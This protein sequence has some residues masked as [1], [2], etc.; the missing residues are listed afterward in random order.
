[1]RKGSNGVAAALAG[2]TLLATGTG[3]FAPGGVGWAA[4]PRTAVLASSANAVFGA[5]SKATLGAKTAQVSIQI[6]GTEQASGVGPCEWKIEYCS[7]TL[8]ITIPGSGGAATT[9]ETA[10]EVEAGGDVYYKLPVGLGGSAT[11]P[12][13]ETSLTGTAGSESTEDEDPSQ[14][15][16][17]LKEYATSVIRVGSADVGAVATTEYSANFNPADLKGATAEQKALGTI[18]LK[19]WLDGRHRIVQLTETLPVSSSA[20]V[21]TSTVPPPTTLT[22]GFSHYGEA[23]T[24]MIPPASEVTQE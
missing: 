23:V 16:L 4:T 15:L 3:L 21:P 12:W 19:V 7:F 17:Y 20:S 11:K 8:H 18:P 24:V 1:V 10:S 2:L 6:A 22:V 5:A 13:T 14:I 9:S